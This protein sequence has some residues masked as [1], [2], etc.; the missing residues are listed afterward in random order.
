VVQSTSGT[1]IAAWTDNTNA[2]FLVA[3]GDS[4][5]ISAFLGKSMA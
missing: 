4:R 2:Y 5:A 1:T 3:R